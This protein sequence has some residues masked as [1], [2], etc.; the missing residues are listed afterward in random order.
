M[1]AVDPTDAVERGGCDGGDGIE[2]ILLGGPAPVGAQPSRAEIW[3]DLM[4]NER[5][6]ET[7]RRLPTGESESGSFVHWVFA[8]DAAT[9][10]SLGVTVTD[11]GIELDLGRLRN[12]LGGSLRWERN[13]LGDV[14]L[15]LVITQAPDLIGSPLE[16]AIYEWRGL[17]TRTKGMA[18]FLIATNLF[19]E[20]IAER[21]EQPK[22]AHDLDPSQKSRPLASIRG[23]QLGATV[24]ILLP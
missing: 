1:S 3:Q 19:H 18:R 24:R 9:R 5:S 17:D 21:W 2:P 4:R 11:V 20:L 22:S 7:V 16:H 12:V 8:L 15:D 6:T 13:T 10:T 14:L 23:V